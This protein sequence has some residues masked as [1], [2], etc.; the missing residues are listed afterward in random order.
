MSKSFQCRIM[1]IETGDCSEISCSLS[2]MFRSVFGRYIAVL[3]YFYVILVERNSQLVEHDHD[4]GK[5]SYV[6]FYCH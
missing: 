1:K 6:L 4:V 3:C 5:S 2:K